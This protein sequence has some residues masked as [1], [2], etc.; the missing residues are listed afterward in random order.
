MMNCEGIRT[1]RDRHGVRGGVRV[2]EVLLFE[3]RTKKRVHGY[4]K[5]LEEMCAER[6]ILIESRQGNVLRNNTVT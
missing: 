1:I 2:E 3:G 6:G 4:T 5:M